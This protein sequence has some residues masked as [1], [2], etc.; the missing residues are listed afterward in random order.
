[1]ADLKHVG[2]MK[3]SDERVVVPYRTIAGDSDSAV[4]ISTAK[5]SP[6]DRDAM[7]KVVESNAGLSAF[8]LY[9]V[10]TRS[11]TPD[12]QN[13][14]VKFHTNGNMQKVSTDS[15]VM[16]PNTTTTIGLD[17]LNKIIAEQKGV[18]I[19]DLA[20]KPDTATTT[21]TFARAPVHGAATRRAQRA[22]VATLAAP[23]G[24]LPTILLPCYDI[25]ACAWTPASYCLQARAAST[26]TT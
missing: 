25:C 3:G 19:D 18:S 10:L 1:M 9:E 17:E 24:V 14:L 26:T 5:I 8:E 21:A 7:M 13:M 22:V 6:E 11:V 2:K 16:T 12:G 15:V 23:G 4:V 20:V